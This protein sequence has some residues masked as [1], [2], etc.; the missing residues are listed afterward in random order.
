MSSYFDFYFAICPHMFQYDPTFF[1]NKNR[2][3]LHFDYN[4]L[5]E[6]R[7]DLIYTYNILNHNVAQHIYFFT[8]TISF[9]HMF[10][11]L[12]QTKD[13]SKKNIYIYMKTY[14]AFKP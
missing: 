4:N 7:I 8:V 11:T 14:T 6:T 13:K 2:T 1:Q 9:L 3:Y 12:Y 10:H 5:D